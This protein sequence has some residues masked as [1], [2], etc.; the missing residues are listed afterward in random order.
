MTAILH[1]ED[2]IETRNGSVKFD[3]FVDSPYITDRVRN[4]RVV[5][6]VAREV[7]LTKGNVEPANAQ[8]E[9][10]IAIPKTGYI[11]KIDVEF[12]WLKVRAR[13]LARC[14]IQLSKKVS[15]LPERRLDEKLCFIDSKLRIRRGT[16][17]L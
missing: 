3:A 4:Q 13:I 1:C 5:D 9:L 7:F 12:S 2:I 17:C 6:G 8:V 16:V 15:V 14:N 10:P 11:L